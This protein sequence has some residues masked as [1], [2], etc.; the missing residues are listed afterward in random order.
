MGANATTFVPAYV[1]GEVLTAA[2][3]TVT[4]SGI[5]VFATTVTR[6]AAFGGTGEKVLAEGQFAYLEDTNTTQYYDGAAWQSVAPT[7]QIA[8]FNETQA[9]GTSGG[10]NATTT[11]TKRVLNTSVYNSIT[12]CSIASSVITLPA[13]TFLVTSDSPYLY[14]GR[15][16]V[17]LRNTTAS[18]DAII[19]GNAYVNPT[20][21]DVVVIAPLTGTVVTTGST[22]FELQYYAAFAGGATNGLGVAN[23]IASIS[24]V[25]ATITIEKIA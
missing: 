15:V 25:Y 13:G 14:T 2:D 24:E 12:G 19:G 9:S 5:P 18:S 3:L 22:N 21:A 10:T 23:S 4:N 7:R 17:K 11:W 1:S 16:K 8:I 6:D 20:S